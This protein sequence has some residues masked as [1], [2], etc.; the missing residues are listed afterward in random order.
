MRWVWIA[1]TLASA[2]GCT[3]SIADIGPPPQHPTYNAQV[4]PLLHDH[5]LL[6]HSSPPD[7]GAPKYFRLDVY[8][9]QGQVAGAQTYAGSILSDVL[10]D[11]PQLLPQGLVRGPHL[12]PPGGGVGPNGKQ[13][14]INWFNDGA[15]E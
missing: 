8:A 3:Y 5:C 9:D 12:M 10:H 13:L 14:L 15:P 11:E 2:S 7:R 4:R 1:V 6:C